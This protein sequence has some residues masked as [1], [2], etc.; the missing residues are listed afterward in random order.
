[1]RALLVWSIPDYAA[2]SSI[3]YAPW[4]KRKKIRMRER[5]REARQNESEVSKEH[6][7]IGGQTNLNYS[8]IFV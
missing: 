8:F 4:N 2:D 3:A 1:M 5:E 7:K 6:N